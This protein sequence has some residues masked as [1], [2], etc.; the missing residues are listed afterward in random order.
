MITKNTIFKLMV[1]TFII[2]FSNFAFSEEKPS[3]LDLKKK[4]KK[5]EPAK[6]EEPKKEE[7]KVAESS[8][9]SAP[10]EAQ[11]DEHK[12]E[13]KK[14]STKPKA[15]AKSAIRDSQ[16]E[17]P[18]TESPQDDE[19]RLTKNW[20]GAR[21]KLSANGMDLAVTYK[22]DV[23]RNT[24]GGLQRKNH[25]L[26]N[27][28]LKASIDG[29]K[30]VDWKGGSM[31]FYGIYSH[32]NNPTQMVGDLQGTSNIET[33]VTTWK[34][35]EAWAQQ[36]FWEDK[37]SFLIGLHDLNSEF[38]VTESAGMFLN[39][40]FGVGKEFS[41]TGRNGPS[42]FPTTAPAIRLRG[43][44]SKSFYIQWAV[45]NGQ[46]GDPTNLNST[47]FRLKQSDGLL[48]IN[49]MAYLRGKGEME[50]KELPGKYGIGVWTYTATFDHQNRTYTLSDGV[51][52]H[53][54]KVTS[55]GSYFLIDQGMTERSSFFTRFGIASTKANRV[56]SDLAAGVNIKVFWDLDLK[57]V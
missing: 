42:I 23:V 51:S 25:Y 35:Y 31:F 8:H 14:K 26:G 55:S 49:E 41:Q 44:P 52:T 47:N 39:G 20:G 38:Y 53:A 45:F 17:K 7:V 12:T 1:C 50:G 46:A 21:K 33:A 30:F 15:P 29:E 5:E 4:E 54:E 43:E 36:L 57:I 18:V 27:L 13:K 2:S 37:V 16:E 22:A 34:L 56:A 28:D 9:A 40:S 32:G 3:F 24:A 48:I 6:K 11:N 19:T 10:V